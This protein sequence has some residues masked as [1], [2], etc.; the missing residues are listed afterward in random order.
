MVVVVLITVV[1]IVVVLWRQAK[2]FRIKKR[3]ERTYGESERARRTWQPREGG[4]DGCHVGGAEE[5]VVE[6][7]LSHHF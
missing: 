1:I 6:H 5:F 2:V 7:Y 3:G 4:E